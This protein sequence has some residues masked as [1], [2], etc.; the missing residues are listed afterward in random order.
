MEE[1]LK[2]SKKVVLLVDP[3]VG[4]TSLIQKFVRDIFDDEYLKTLGTKVTNKELTFQSSDNTKQIVEYTIPHISETLKRL[5][6]SMKY[7][8]PVRLTHSEVEVL[9]WLKE[10]KSSWS[11]SKILDKSQSVVEFH[12]KNI[13]R[14]LDASN[15]THAV[16]I[17]I[18]NGFLN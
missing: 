14:K 5:S 6:S 17:A 15:R 11:I 2:I 1:T 16:I 3:A 18:E 10:G 7:Q 9:T 12:V 4:K 13:L 8:R